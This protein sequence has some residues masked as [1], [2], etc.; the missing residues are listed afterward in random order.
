MR[1]VNSDIVYEMAFES[2]IVILLLCMFYVTVLAERLD[3][4]LSSFR[5][6]SPKPERTAS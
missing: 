2:L 6:R 5:P 1:D 4:L 3:A